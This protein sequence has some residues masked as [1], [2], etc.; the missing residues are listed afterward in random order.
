MSMDIARITSG[1]H[2]PPPH[3]LHINVEEMKTYRDD[4][5]GHRCKNII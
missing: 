5:D 4:G 2:V 3:T 1:G